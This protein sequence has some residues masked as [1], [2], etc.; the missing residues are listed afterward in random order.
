MEIYF[1]W[2][3]VLHL[4][5]YLLLLVKMYLE[6]I[7]STPMGQQ[8]LHMSRIALPRQISLLQGHRMPSLDHLLV[9]IGMINLL[10]MEMEMEMAMDSD[11]QPSLI[12]QALSG[13]R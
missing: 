5:L 9:R 10:W 4:P 13:D 8:E 1:I 2:M 7:Q 6:L 3:L 12:S 11:G